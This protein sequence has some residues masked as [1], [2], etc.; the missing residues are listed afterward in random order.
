MGDIKRKGECLKVNFFSVF[1]CLSA[2]KLRKIVKIFFYLFPHQVQ[3]KMESERQNISFLFD[4]LPF[5]LDKRISKKEILLTNRKKGIYFIYLNLLLFGLERYY[6][7][8]NLP[9]I[10]MESKERKEP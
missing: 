7:F 10:D 5:H 4:L 6:L 2:R 3:Q 9:H 8:D 1:V